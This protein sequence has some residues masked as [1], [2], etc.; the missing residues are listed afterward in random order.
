MWHDNTCRQQSPRPT[1]L[2]ML[3]WTLN[4]SSMCGQQLYITTTD[5]VCVCVLTHSNCSTPRHIIAGFC[6]SDTPLGCVSIFLG[7]TQ[8]FYSNRMIMSL[9]SADHSRTRALNEWTRDAAPTSN[10]LCYIWRII[11]FYIVLWLHHFS[12]LV[13]VLAYS[14]TPWVPSYRLYAEALI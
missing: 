7:Q 10:I 1:A 11:S 5:R 2:M 12:M 13:L 4:S 8:N 6:Y 3:R 9:W 14:Q